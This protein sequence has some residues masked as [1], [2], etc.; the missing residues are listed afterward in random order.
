MCTIASSAHFIQFT[1]A[2]SFFYITKLT[3]TT[4]V[5]FRLAAEFVA[6]ASEGILLGDFNNWNPQEGVQLQKIADGSMT[7]EIALVAG[8]TYQYRYLLNDGRWV[9]DFSGTTEWVEAFGNYVEN[10]VVE[11]PGNS[12]QPTLPSEKTAP[13]KKVSVKTPALKKE[14]PAVD[15]LTKI[16]GVGKKIAALLKKKEILT[17]KDLGKTSIKSLKMILDEAGPSF[18]IHNPSSW[19]KQAKLAAAGR[20]DELT[21]LQ[22]TLTAGK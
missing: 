18:N 10:N 21:V 20:W 13:K 4:K 5:S 22:Q 3:M 14:K 1:F 19:P 7:A 6:N 2:A 8:K 11:V 9:N 17:Y 16:E 15:D 12:P